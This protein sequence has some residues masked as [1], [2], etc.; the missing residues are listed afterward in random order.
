MLK[1][2]GYNSDRKQTLFEV[3]P[4]H[5]VDLIDFRK[6]VGLKM[7]AGDLIKRRSF[8][9]FFHNLKYAVKREDPYNT[10]DWLMDL[11]EKHNLKSRFY[12]MS[13]GNNP[14]DGNY[15]LT[16]PAL[17]GLFDKINKRRHIIGFHP[18]FDTYKDPETFIKE[19]TALE[20]KCGNKITEG[21]QHCLRFEVPV[22]W[23]VWQDAGMKTDCTLGY[24]QAEGFRCGTA[25]E[26]PVFDF[27]N[28]TRLELRELPL[29]AMDGTL[30]QYR[31]LSINEARE[32]LCNLKDKC[33]KYRI[34]FT[35]LFHNSSFDKA[36]WKGYRELY[37]Y[38]LRY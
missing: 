11:S 5:D 10:F 20:K 29:I 21:R 31:R 4:T 32:S 14:N 2:L 34:P 17:N 26:Y 13:G 38:I 27:E 19:K 33:R 6:I 3:I 24:S 1:A 23:R 18:S 15:D 37:E 36:R 9:I 12:F 16:H 35:I 30:N 28:Q 25:R 22:T 7:L 8:H